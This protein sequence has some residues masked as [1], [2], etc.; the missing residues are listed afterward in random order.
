MH[1]KKIVLS[2]DS[3]E[4]ILVVGSVAY[5]SIITPYSQRER[6]LGGSA[7]Y[8]SLAA[9]HYTSPRLV[10]VVGEDFNPDYITLFEEHGIC[11]EGLKHDKSGPTFYWKGEYSQ[12]WNSRETLDIQLNV[13]EK[14]QPELPVP[15]RSTPYVMLGNISPELQHHVCDQLQGKPFIIADTIDLWIDIQREALL[16]LLKRVHCI[17]IND[18]EAAQLTQEKNVIRAGYK[19]LEEGLPMAIIKKGEHG[20]CLFHPK[21][22]FALPAYPVTKVQDPTGAGDSFAGAFLGYLAATNKTDFD[23]VKQAMIYATATASMTVEALS[24]DR[25]CSAEASDIE[26]RVEELKKIISL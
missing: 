18:S 26:N 4:S 8:A 17:L 15:Y 3:P 11:L 25:L 7:S 21:G 5:D 14:F 1:S 24:C 22:L 13:F 20:A 16:K 12:D 9:S 23:H 10:G 19:L 2:S 6:C